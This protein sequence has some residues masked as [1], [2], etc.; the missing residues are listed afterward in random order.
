[1]KRSVRLTRGGPLRRRGRARFRGYVRNEPYR[2]WVRRHGCLLV[3]QHE[4]WGLIEFCH[5]TSRG[6]GGVDEGNGFPACSRGHTEQHR[7]SIRSFEAKHNVCLAATA[8]ELWDT[9]QGGF[10]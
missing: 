7:I 8:R 10:Q 5:V 9:Y 3:G 2:Q 6:A 1:M 4:C